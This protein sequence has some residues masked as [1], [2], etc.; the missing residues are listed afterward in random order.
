M[1]PT[2][3]TLI[4][5]MVVLLLLALGLVTFLIRGL[6]KAR[7]EKASALP[8]EE[9]VAKDRTSTHASEPARVNVE[10]VDQSAKPV[11]T[12]KPTAQAVEHR[13]SYPRSA[14]NSR[15]EPPNGAAEPA[16]DLLMQVWQDQEG[17]LVVEV[18]GKRYRRLYDVQDGAVGRRLLE[19][20][21][22]LVAF[23]KG[24]ETGVA[25]EPHRPTRTAAR[26]GVDATFASMGEDPMAT[27]V[28]EVQPQ[29]ETQF[30]KKRISV[31]PVPF[32]R[33]SEANYRGITLD[34]ASEIEQL[35]QLRI[36]ALPEFSQ[37]YIH[38]TSAPD[39]GLR[40]DVDGTRY[41]SLDELKDPN[42]QT[43]IRAA[44]SDWEA[45]R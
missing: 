44:I 35:L 42:V 27:L 17:Y 31:D 43:L 3:G 7:S 10:A 45:R 19:T 13:N 12:P 25:H 14:Q 24:K 9:T 33:R 39:G 34:L 30:K 28:E 20:V 29:A 6:R 23:S 21:S 15:L 16:G 4:G 41:S 1:E 18:E 8:M 36:K 11:P 40:F 32:R 26:S 2:L 22:R 38:V 5:L 37:R